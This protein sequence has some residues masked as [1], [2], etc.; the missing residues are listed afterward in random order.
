MKPARGNGSTCSG[1]C[2]AFLQSPLIVQI[3]VSNLSK[4]YMTWFCVVS[5]RYKLCKCPLCD[6]KTMVALQEAGAITEGVAE[7]APS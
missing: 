1:Q 4:T 6:F 2:A 3:V 7:A 5:G